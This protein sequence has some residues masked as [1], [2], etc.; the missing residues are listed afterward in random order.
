MKHVLLLLAAVALSLQLSS[1][2]SMFGGCNG[3][4]A[5]TYEETYKVKTCSHDIIREERVIDAKSG[6]VEVTEKKV[7]RYKEKTRTVYVRCP[8]CVRFYCPTAGCCGSGGEYIDRMKTAQGPTG[9]PHIGQIPTMK[10]LA[11]AE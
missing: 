2:C 1:C 7:P 9:S 3:G 8:K 4:I 10:V 6:L 5:G 11:P